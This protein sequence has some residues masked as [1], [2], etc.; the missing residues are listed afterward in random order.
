MVDGVFLNDKGA[1]TSVIYGYTGATPPAGQTF[2]GCDVTGLQ[3]GQ[4]APSVAH[5]SLAATDTS[6]GR[7]VEDLVAALI[8][9]G[10]LQRSDIPAGLLNK[11][12]GRRALRNQT[13]L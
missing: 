1:I 3:P 4:P 2:L 13:A 12:N 6:L 7:G 8:A 10:T 5:Q 9:K 11:I